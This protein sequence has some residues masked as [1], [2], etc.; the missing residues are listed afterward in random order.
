MASHWGREWGRTYT[1]MT[2]DDY[3]LIKRN[4]S[5]RIGGYAAKVNNENVFE[6]DK[7]LYVPTEQTVLFLRAFSNTESLVL[8]GRNYLILHDKN[9]EPVVN[10]NQTE[11]KFREWLEDFKTQAVI[12]D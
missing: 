5:V 9:L 4:N 10:T 2:S 12:K 7:H 3:P 11:G 6:R 8:S 1:V